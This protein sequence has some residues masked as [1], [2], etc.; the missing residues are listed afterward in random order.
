ME[1][2]AV[3]VNL[4]SANRRNG[5]QRDVHLTFL[6]SITRFETAASISDQEVQH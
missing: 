2:D 4:L 6:K 3:P 1:E 5:P